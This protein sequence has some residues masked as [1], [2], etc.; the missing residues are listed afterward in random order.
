MGSVMEA[1]REKIVSA[2]AIEYAFDSFPYYLSEK[3]RD[4]LTYV[5]T[6][7][8]QHYSF[9]TFVHNIETL[10]RRILLTGPT[11][12]SRC[13]AALAAAVAKHSGADMLTFDWDLV[14]GDEEEE[15]EEDG[16][17]LGEYLDELDFYEEI[18]RQF[19]STGEVKS[20]YG[21]GGKWI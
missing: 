18:K 11:G 16:N 15:N 5:A 21:I 2:D 4:R 7:Y 9:A 12:S 1:I 14:N 13:L 19:A 20:R 6:V 8:F 3:V 10:N 17:G